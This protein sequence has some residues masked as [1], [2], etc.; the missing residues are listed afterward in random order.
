KI[1]ICSFQSASS[2]GRPCCI[3]TRVKCL[4][5]SKLSR[6]KSPDITVPRS[7]GENDADIG[8]GWD[9]LGEPDA[10][11]VRALRLAQIVEHAHFGLILRTAPDLVGANGRQPAVGRPAIACGDEL[12]RDAQA[13]GLL[14][15][16][17]IGS[18]QAFAPCVRIGSQL[19]QIGLAMIA[20]R[21]ARMR[22]HVAKSHAAELTAGDTTSLSKMQFS[23][24]AT[25][26]TS[27]RP[28]I[29]ERE[30]VSTTGATARSGAW[31]TA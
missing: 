2:C 1:A 23:A 13:L 18:W 26:C 29:V 20:R 11:S 22:R 5:G 15:G 21:R 30:M 25:A 7:T 10:Q 14:H 31:S 24:R 3:R 4:C 9:V 28:R 8:T 16:V 17:P 12:W 19:R 27:T 6:L